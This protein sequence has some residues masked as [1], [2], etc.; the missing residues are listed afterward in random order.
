MHIGYML[1]ATDDE[2]VYFCLCA[3]PY[4]LLYDQSLKRCSV[5]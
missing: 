1:E 5:W 2:R 4:W 3:V